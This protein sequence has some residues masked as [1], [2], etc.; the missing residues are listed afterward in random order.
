LP[1]RFVPAACVL[2]AVS[3]VRSGLPDRPALM[4]TQMA[5][6]HRGHV[7]TVGHSYKT[8]DD[9]F[10]ADYYRNRDFQMT[11]PEVV[12]FVVRSVA[13][14]LVQPL[15]WNVASRVELAYMPELFLWCAI[16][17]LFPL[18][19]LLAFRREPLLTCVLGGYTLV[20]V[21][22]IALNSGNIG[23][24]VRHRA[25]AVPYMIWMSAA[26]LIAIL[27]KGGQHVRG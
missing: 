27:E 11:N 3:F 2:A 24:V 20:N 14:Y 15:P 16:V 25:L 7:F 18:G 9:R 12:R 8:L 10:Y 6:Y 22:I 17:V 19:C 5:T 21:L 4:I 13:N 1:A 26:G 23:T